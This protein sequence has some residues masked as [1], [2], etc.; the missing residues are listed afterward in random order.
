MIDAGD[1]LARVKAN[2][3]LLRGCTKP[4]EFEAIEPAKIGSKF[5]CRKCGGELDCVHAHWYN[6]GLLDARKAQP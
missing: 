4:H 1:I 3:A 5:R 6:Q 2:I